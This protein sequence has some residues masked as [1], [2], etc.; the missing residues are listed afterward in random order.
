MRIWVGDGFWDK[1][2]T[3]RTPVIQVVLCVT[4]D[5]VSKLPVKVISVYHQRPSPVSPPSILSGWGSIST[6]C[7]VSVIRLYWEWVRPRLLLSIVKNSWRYILHDR[8]WE[9]YKVELINRVWETPL[10]MI[11][12]IRTKYVFLHIRVYNSLNKLWYLGCLVHS[13]SLPWLGSVDRDPRY[14]IVVTRRYVSE[15]LLLGRKWLSS[16]REFKTFL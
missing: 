11:I 3:V 7:F 13:L 14:E 8:I 2:E 9:T 1:T 15:P 16:V 5:R 10:T 6:S 12:I 4:P